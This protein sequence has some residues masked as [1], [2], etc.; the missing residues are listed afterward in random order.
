MGFLGNLL[1]DVTGKSKRPEIKGSRFESF[2]SEEIFTD[3]TQ[4]CYK[5][6]RLVTPSRKG[7]LLHNP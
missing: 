2:L 7:Y 6:D 4:K 3:K 5:H 1:E